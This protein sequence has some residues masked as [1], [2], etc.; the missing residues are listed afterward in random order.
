MQTISQKYSLG[1]PLPGLQEVGVVAQERGRAKEA[2]G[3]AEDGERV[4]DAQVER[5]QVGAHVLVNV[6]DADGEEWG[7]ADP[8]Q[9]VGQA[10]E[11]H[12]AE[13]A[14][15]QSERVHGVLF[16]S[17]PDSVKHKTQPHVGNERIKC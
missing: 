2:H 15:L 14:G 9:E 10:E 4:E 16:L 7:G 1:E 3:R 17:I 11:E 13:G 8:V 6:G 12:V 5:G